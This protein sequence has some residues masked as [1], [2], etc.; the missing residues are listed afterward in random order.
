MSAEPTGQKTPSV[1]DLNVLMVRN[2]FSLK[3]FGLTIDSATTRKEFITALKR[4]R[5]RA[6]V[7]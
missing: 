2:Y 3:Y 7:R 6:V 5:Q 4:V 1:V